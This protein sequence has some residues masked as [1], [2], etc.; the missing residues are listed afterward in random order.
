MHHISFHLG[1]LSV[2]APEIRTCSSTEVGIVTFWLMDPP[3]SKV[4]LEINVERA[5]AAV[6]LDV[7]VECNS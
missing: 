4:P 2:R 6:V 1:V 7:P 3:P 5:Q